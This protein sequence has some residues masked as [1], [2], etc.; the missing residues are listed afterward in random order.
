MVP[1][2]GD[3][4]P[5][6]LKRP[7]DK[8]QK[9]HIR[10]TYAAD[11]KPIIHLREFDRIVRKSEKDQTQKTLLLFLEGIMEYYAPI[12]RYA[13]VGNLKE[14]KTSIFKYL[15][16]WNLALLC[17]NFLGERFL[18]FLFS[19]ASGRQF[20]FTTFCLCLQHLK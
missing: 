4:S 19:V 2:G 9:M 13:I 7:S 16:K 10:L 6:V 14:K 15:G 1:C 11:D 8:N 5:R 20:C 18:P 3:S 12:V 17:D